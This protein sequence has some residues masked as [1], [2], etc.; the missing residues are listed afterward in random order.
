MTF[1]KITYKLFILYWPLVMLNYFLLMSTKINLTIFLVDVPL[2]FFM[3]KSV[4]ICSKNNKNQFVAFFSICLALILLTIGDYVFNDTPFVCYLQALQYYVA[5]L[6]FAPLGY[7]LATNHDYNKYYIYACAAC[8]VIGFYLY[9]TLPPYY[10]TYLA[11]VQGF[12]NYRQEELMGLTRFSSFLP[13][14]YNISY[15]S[16]PALILSLA[17]SS[18]EHANIKKWL[19]YV[20]A[21]ISFIAAILCQQR[22]AMFFAVFV[23][24]FYLF[25]F[26]NRGNKK[27]IIIV[28]G[29]VLLLF[30]IINH[31]VSEMAFF[32]VL[33]ENIIDRYQKMDFSV[34]MAERTGQYSGFNRATN[35]SYFT[36]LGLG[37]CGHLAIPYNL[38][39]INDGEFV[40]TFYEFGFFITLL[41]FI[42]VL[43]TLVRGLRLF[44]FLNAEVLIMIFFLGAC[45]GAS[46][47]TFFIY[48][49]MFWFAMGR[50]WNKNYLAL[51]K[52]EYAKNQIV[53]MN[54][55]S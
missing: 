45:F 48:S 51:R 54:H 2:V 23:V 29:V 38:Q 46:A 36:G 15:L 7:S 33:K 21:V 19:S 50:I 39:T 13:G 34:A 32:D 10:M 37:S 24:V 30:A 3:L 6:C 14:S 17:Y 40:K 55:C 49:S 31:F 47:L 42:L 1:D 44:K 27:F 9:A 25:Y 12:E 41:L 26:S 16:V 22:I 8:F 52:Q 4:L 35:W 43:I 53:K 28:L 11:E 18:N 20:I 5:P